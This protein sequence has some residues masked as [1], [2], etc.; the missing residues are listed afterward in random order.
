MIRTTLIAAALA[1]VCATAVAAP[2]AARTAAPA[3]V[4]LD[5]NGDGA[6]DR[7]EA[8]KAPRLA[9]GFDRMVGLS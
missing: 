1:A 3:R 8:A 9:Q 4:K 7:A 5:A 6:I 2:Q